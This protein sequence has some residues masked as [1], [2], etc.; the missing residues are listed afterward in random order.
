M[1]LGAYAIFQV[2]LS[3]N[4]VF[5]FFLLNGIEDKDSR[6]IS[7]DQVY[8]MVPVSFLARIQI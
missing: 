1:F 8:L 7:S 2:F 3:K 5:V 6:F 4:Y